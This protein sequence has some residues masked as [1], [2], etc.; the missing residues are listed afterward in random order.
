MKL[1]ELINVGK[2]RLS[3]LYPEKEAAQMVFSYLEYSLGTKRHT[4][5]IEPDY[6]VDTQ[7]ASLALD[8][9]GRMSEGEPLQYVT[10][11]SWFYDRPFKV[12][13]AVLIPRPETELLVHEMLKEMP[14]SVLDLCTGSGC[15]AWTLALELPGTEVLAADISD[16]ALEVAI[17]QDFSEEISRTGAK[18]PTFVKADVLKPALDL[19]SPVTPRR[20]DA[21]VS[22]PPYVMDSERELMRQNVLEHE[23]HLALFVPDED[24]LLFYRALARHSATHLSASGVGLV[25]INE[26]LGKQTSAVFQERGFETEVLTDFSGRD[27]FVKFRFA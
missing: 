12:S 19:T 17:S 15:I 13:P 24:P 16:E 4:H 3:V 6:E 20:F 18:A 14:A 10:G 26:A 23:P 25:E 5:L 22:N 2:K 9:F 11:I 27:R 1:T 7:R 8:A 21:I